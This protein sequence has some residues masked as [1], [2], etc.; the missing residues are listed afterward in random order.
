MLPELVDVEPA[1]RDPFAFGDEFLDLAHD[2]GVLEL[3]VPV[4]R[5]A[6]AVRGPLVGHVDR[7]DWDV[8]E[9]LPCFRPLEVGVAR[10]RRD[11]Q[12]RPWNL[13]H[14]M[15]AAAQVHRDVGLQVSAD[16]RRIPVVLRLPQIALGGAPNR[17]L[18]RRDL[19]IHD[20]HVEGAQDLVHVA[21]DE[22]V[23]STVAVVS[24][25]GER[26][27]PLARQPRR[28]AGTSADDRGIG[29]SVDTRLQWICS[30]SSP[31]VWFD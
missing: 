25:F 29:L 11:D 8:V 6:L 30:H 9:T 18:Q 23:C 28:F 3:E 24:R 26:R 5:H 1:L 16:V 19:R 10:I 7:H 31:A 14:R 12:R 2:V 4:A 17:R 13:S 15:T 21:H 20:G 27:E 22:D